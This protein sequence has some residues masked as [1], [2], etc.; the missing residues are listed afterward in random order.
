MIKIFDKNI[1]EVKIINNDRKEIYSD[2]D[3]VKFFEN[4]LYRATL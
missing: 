1:I 2:K 3:K 4:G